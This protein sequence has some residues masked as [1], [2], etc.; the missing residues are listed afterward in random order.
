MVVVHTDYLN[1][2]NI[3]FKGFNEEVK[4]KTSS[5]LMTILTTTSPKKNCVR[6]FFL[7]T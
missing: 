4:K 7:R 2:C 5:H 6:K 3:F 1:K